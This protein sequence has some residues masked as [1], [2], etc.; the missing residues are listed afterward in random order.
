MRETLTEVIGLLIMYACKWVYGGSLVGFQ[1]IF[2]AEI[3][4][5]SYPLRGFAALHREGVWQLSCVPTM[6]NKC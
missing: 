2:T 1:N 5:R 6:K 4:Y 3:T